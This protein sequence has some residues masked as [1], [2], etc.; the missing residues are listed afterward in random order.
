MNIVLYQMNVI[1]PKNNIMMNI[2]EQIEILQAYRDGKIIQLKN[3]D[4]W[5]DLEPSQTPNFNFGLGVYRIK[6]KQIRPYKLDELIQAIKIH[7]LL[8]YDKKEETYHT[9]SQFNYSSMG[10]T[11][12]YYDDV[13]CNFVMSYYADNERFEWADDK[14]P[15]GI[16]EE[17]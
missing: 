14:S 5:I 6:P 10:Y 3:N 7:G 8:F 16:I 15:M 4:C 12:C 9:I 2:H 11:D 13:C 17:N 1:K